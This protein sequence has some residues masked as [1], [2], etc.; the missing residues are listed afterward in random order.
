MK[1]HDVFN[2]LHCV[3]KVEIFLLKKQDHQI[4]TNFDILNLYQKNLFYS[5]II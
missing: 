5:N 3:K 1:Q 2:F 4:Y